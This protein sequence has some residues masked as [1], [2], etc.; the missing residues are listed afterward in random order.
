M[1]WLDAIRSSFGHRPGGAAPAVV[2][3][4]DSIT[5]FWSDNDP[6][7]FRPGRLNRGISGDTTGQ[8]RARFD[9]DV[10]PL[11]PQL[12]HIM[13]GTN[14]LWRGLPG[15]DAGLA[16]AN[17]IDMAERAASGGACVI[18]AAP[19]P[20]APSALPMFSHADLLPVMRSALERHCRE[21]GYL[22]VDYAVSLCDAAGVLRPAFTTDGVHLT[23][24][25][26]RAMRRQAE[27]A[28]AT[29]LQG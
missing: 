7:L 2:F 6:V 11:R 9:H 14:D 21:A 19:P 26:Y 18:L 16:I 8:M 5:Q 13:G 22:Y 23:R 17:L 10:L 28:I 27:R 3:I 12:V 1:T 20:I 15:D 29:A 24:K 25:G 4:G